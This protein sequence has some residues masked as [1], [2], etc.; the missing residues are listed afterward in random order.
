M[1]VMWLVDI[2]NDD[3][4]TAQQMLV[5]L[6]S[7]GLNGNDTV[8]PTYVALP[9]EPNLAAI[10]ESATSYVKK[11]L[12]KHIPKKLTFDFSIR[13]VVIEANTTS[14]RKIAD[15]ALAEAKKNLIS[16]VTL[17]TQN[18]EG[19]KNFLL[20]SFAETFIY[21]SRLS[22][23]VLNPTSKPAKKLEKILYATDLESGSLDG[24]LHAASIAKRAGASLCLFHIPQPNYTGG[25]D[26]EPD[27]DT[28]KYQKSVQRKLNLLLVAAQK[29]GVKTNLLI[30]AQW[31][32]AADLILKAAAAEQANLIVVHA[33]KS[34]LSN[35]FLGST[36]S[37]LI[38][39]SQ[40]PVYILRF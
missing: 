21:R 5:T 37:T 30:D 40:I 26:K 23:L 16:L 38:R 33:K 14:F 29:N 27:A 8:Q 2:F 17:Q 6:K 13:P 15:H 22:M 11:L 31:Q 1:K 39:S 20:G 9:A 35:L 24:V 7:L 28:L 34:A 4:E 25:S 19:F 18:K 3:I 32:S 12:L 36:T 10:D